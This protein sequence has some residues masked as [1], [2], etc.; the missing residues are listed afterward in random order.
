MCAEIPDT[1]FDA[2]TNVLNEVAAVDTYD[3]RFS[4][5]LFL[6]VRS[7]TTFQAVFG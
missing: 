1:S 6:N 5:I 2:Y 7:L 4:L 3:M